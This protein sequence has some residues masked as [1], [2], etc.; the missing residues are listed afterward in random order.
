MPGRKKPSGDGRQRLRT[1]NF[2]RYS[3]RHMAEERHAAE[4]HGKGNIHIPPDGVPHRAALAARSGVDGGEK[5]V[6]FHH[7]EP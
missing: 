4:D 3:E 5:L 7:I 1:V 6:L 2:F